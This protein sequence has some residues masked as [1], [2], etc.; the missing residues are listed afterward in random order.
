MP[1]DWKLYEQDVIDKY[2][3]G[4]KNTQETIAYLRQEHGVEIRQFK[5]KFGGL[6]KLH[7]GIDTFGKH[8]LEIRDPA[9]TNTGPQH[10]F[11]SAPPGLMEDSEFQGVQETEHP[12]QPTGDEIDLNPETNWDFVNLDLSTPRLEDHTQFP[13][14]DLG[15]P[16]NRDATITR[17]FQD[18]ELL[19]AAGQGN[20][21]LTK[22]ILE[23]GI[24]EVDLEN[25][26]CK[27]IS[28]NHHDAVMTFL[29]RGVD[30][31]ARESQFMNFEDAEYSYP[32]QIATSVNFDSEGALDSAYLLIKAGA[33][34]NDG[35]LME[36]CDM[37]IRNEEPEF[38]LL[39]L[40]RGYDA[41]LFGASVM[42]FAANK[43][44]IYLCGLFLDAG[45]PIN[46]Y[47]RGGR[48][49]LQ[50]AASHDNFSLVKYLVKQGADVNLPASDDGG[51]TALQAAARNGNSE[52]IDWLIEEGA[53][54]KATAAIRNGMTVLE[55][56]ACGTKGN[57]MSFKYLLAL[58][59]PV[60]RPNGASGTVLHK[61]IRNE[62]IEG[63]K[64]ALEAGARVDDRDCD[65]GYRDRDS[66]NRYFGIGDRDCDSG[67]MTPLQVAASY[68]NGEAI[69]LLLSH[70]AGI[71]AL[72]GDKNGRT[73]LQAA[74]AGVEGRFSTIEE[75]VK[76]IEL[77][78]LYQADINAPAGKEFGRT[79]LQA[80]TSS[81]NP[82][83]KIVAFLLDHAADVN[84][85]PS[86][87]GGVTALQGAAIKGDMQIA[88]ILLKHN[89]EVNAAP[90]LEEG[91]TAVEGA[92]EHGRM[93]MVRLL[94]NA[95]A[96]PDPENGF[97]RAIELAD[98]NN[99]F[100]IGDLLKEVK[101]SFPSA[102]WTGLLTSP[103]PWLPDQGMVMAEE[104]DLAI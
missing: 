33:D 55:A 28:G 5:S 99:H 27:A 19:E 13:V 81:D 93:D 37:A 77:L 43:R 49:A 24:S 78:L 61:L 11:S 68:S 87:K 57:L 63:L 21:T 25:A 44:E 82:E 6:K 52:L 16:R 53:D 9:A 97:T 73:A 39:L 34:I 96:R 88:R 62:Q 101:E 72:A 12:M 65:S 2:V 76:T 92:A 35:V 100:V 95:G 91:R 89:A 54:V 64:L 17:A 45:A 79:A 1:V 86:T 98:K 83:P 29:N 14:L 51:E 41:A 32:I 8:R 58:G 20:I 80:A 84:A 48:S 47:G 46:K 4:E 85:A 31:N 59:A 67:D 94:L 103:C 102:A 70:G 71:N 38:M 3:N 50:A 69:L 36:I 75:K 66:G 10:E 56:A 60:N 15:F 90:A 26:L 7:L 40:Q 42:E 18:F 23:H 22:W 104:E 30:P 74:V